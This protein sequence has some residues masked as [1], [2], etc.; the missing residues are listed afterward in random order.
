MKVDAQG[1]PIRKLLTDGM[2]IIPDYQR[3]YDWEEEQICE[4]IDDI[5][6]VPLKYQKRKKCIHMISNYLKMSDTFWR[7]CYGHLILYFKSVYSK[8]R[9]NTLKLN[10][11]W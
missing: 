6:N 9:Y 10:R 7:L 1:M 3:E 2:Y 8:C 11:L 4:F 5:S